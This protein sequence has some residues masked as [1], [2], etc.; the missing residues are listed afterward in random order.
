MKAWKMVSTEY[1][2]NYT[3]NPVKQWNQGTFNHMTNSNESYSLH[4]YSQQVKQHIS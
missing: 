2:S 3:L 1:A 4:S